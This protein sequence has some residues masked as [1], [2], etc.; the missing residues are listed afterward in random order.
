MDILLGLLALWFLAA[1]VVVVF[2]CV[3]SSQVSREE[4]R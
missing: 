2:A 1:G 4:E 3:R